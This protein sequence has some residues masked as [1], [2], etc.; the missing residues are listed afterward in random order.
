M[1]KFNAIRIKYFWKINVLVST[2]QFT[3]NFHSRLLFNHFGLLFMQ[4][5]QEQVVLGFCK[6][7]CHLMRLLWAFYVPIKVQW[8]KSKFEFAK[9]K[10]QYICNIILDECVRIKVRRY[11][12]QLRL[13]S[14]QYEVRVLRTSLHFL[15]TIRRMYWLLNTERSYSFFTSRIFETFGRLKLE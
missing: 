9:Y 11:C 14:E 5:L 8:Q 2:L 7:R 4:Y 1:H 6:L 15:Y 3:F 10:L 13:K 12:T